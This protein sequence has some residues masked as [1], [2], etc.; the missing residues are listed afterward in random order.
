VIGESDMIGWVPVS[1]VIAGTFP[2]SK[3]AGHFLGKILHATLPN[4]LRR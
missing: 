1:Q 4:V 2:P 3:P